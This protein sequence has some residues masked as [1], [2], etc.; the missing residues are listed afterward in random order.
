MKL[1][2]YYLPTLK[3]APKDADTLSAKLM[4]R[5]GLI[6]KV[7]SGLYEWLPLG[8]RVLKKV[9]NIVR[10]EMDRAGANEVWLPVVQPKELWEESGRWTFYGKELLRFTDRKEAGFCIS[11]TAEEA[12]T[13]LIRKD[14]SSYKQLPVCLYQ[15]GTKFRDEIRPRFGVMRAREFYMKDAYSFAA[16][17]ES[18]NEWYQKMYDAYQRIFTRCGFN[19]KAVEADTG[20]IG[21]NFSHEFMVLADTGEDAI[22]DCT[23]GYAANTE[24]AEILPPA[25]IEISEADLKP[26]EQ[27][28]TPKAYTI[29]AVA[30]MLGVPQSKLIK[31]LVFTADGKPVVALV[32]GDHELNEFKFKALLKCNELEKATEE[33]YTQVTG[34]FVGFA[35]AQGLKEKNPNVMIYADNYVKNIVN[36][37]SGGNEKDVHTINVTPR[38]D[39]KVDVYADLKMASAG[40]KCARC[41]KEFSF[42]R[43]IETGHIFKLGTKYSAA[44]HANFLGEDQKEKPMIMG[45]Y[46]IGISRVV[47]AAIEQSH[48]DNGIIWPAPMAPFDVALVAIDYDSNPEV[49]KHADEICAKLENAG[50]SVL[51]DD[52]D[53]RPG[54]KFKDMDLIGLPYRLVVS[55]R[56]VKDGQCEYK[57]R[58][59]KEAVRWNLADA[60][61]KLLAEAGK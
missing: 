59:D 23:C 39:I 6:R 52:R 55:S 43:G 51:L 16:T 11:P 19:F 31:L 56:T 25:D 1:S 61:D 57:K 34:S 3:E 13:D 15:F 4:I 44:M 42:T 7:A 37:V 12:I 18:A 22:A 49:K 9:E 14:V 50:L 54:V 8:L 47:A 2:N 38:R 36:G 58:T 17:D 26:M 32:R 20:S 29:E 60:A 40:D 30:E 10:E 28:A 24:K 21:G 5:A 27:K 53:E 46:G 45:C 35:G 41:G 33:V 48:D